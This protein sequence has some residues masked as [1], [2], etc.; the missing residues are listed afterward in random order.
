M[1][2]PARL[3]IAHCGETSRSRKGTSYKITKLV[4]RNSKLWHENFEFIGLSTG[5][6]LVKDV[7]DDAPEPDAKISRVGPA[8]KRRLIVETEFARVLSVASRDGNTLSPLLRQAWDGDN[9]S[10]KTKKEPMTARGA[11]ISMIG[12][13]TTEE[14]TRKLPDTEAASGFA[15]RYLFVCLVRSQ[16]L[17]EGGSLPSDV[18]YDLE[19]KVA[20]ALERARSLG[21]V[22]LKRTDEAKERWA[23]MYHEMANSPHRGLL[24]AVT[25]RA[26]AQTL[27]LSVAYA[28]VDGSAHIELPHLEA[29]YALWRYCEASAAHIFGG[30]TGN[31]Y[32]DRIWHALDDAPDGQM[33][34][35]DISGTFGRNVQ[36]EVL[37][38]RSTC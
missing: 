18:W 16:Q 11:S 19:V 7:A 36:R 14:L 12:Q 23:E 2:H 21:N 35:T 29:A 20:D 9:L 28:I 22:V 5:E 31:G 30:S 3:F 27:R 17:P 24:G 34:R 15:N 38:K 26:E 33:T 4:F 32:A 1:S 6:G 37:M 8:V 25:A 10:I 13:I